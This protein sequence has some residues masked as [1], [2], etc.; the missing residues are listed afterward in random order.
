FSAFPTL[1]GGTLVDTFNVT[2]A[3]TADLK[4]GDGVDVFNIGAVLTGSVDGE[5]A[6]GT[7]SGSQ[8]AD[9]A[10]TGPSGTIGVS[11]TNGGVSGGFSN[12]NTITGSGAGTLTGSNNASTWALGATKTYTDAA[13]VATFSGF[14]TLQGGTAIDTFNV[15]AATTADLKGGGGVDVFNIGAAL[16]GSVDG[17]AGADTFTGAG[18]SISGALTDAAGTSTLNGTITAGS[19]NLTGDVVLG[20]TTSLNTSA[21]AGNI[22]FQGTLNG[23]TD[24]AEDLTLTAGTGN[25]DFD[26]VVGSTTDLGDVVIVSA[27]NVTA[28]EAFNANTLDVTATNISM[29]DVTTTGSQSYNGA[30]SFG[31]DL[32]AVD[33]T[34]NNAITANGTGNQTFDAG[35]GTLWARSTINKSTAGNLTLAGDTLI[36]LDGAVTVTGDLE[37]DDDTTVADGL[38]LTAGNDL[39]LGA[40]KT[41]TG[42]GDLTLAATAGGITEKAGDVDDN[43]QIDMAVDD[44]TLTLTQNDA[45][46]MDNFVVTNDEDTALDATS[47]GGSVT[48]TSADSWQSI[49]ARATATTGGHNIELSG[50]GNINI[51]SGGLVS[52]SGGVKVVSTGGTISILGSGTPITGTSNGTTTGVDL[53]VLSGGGK[54]A[55]V[56]I[57]EQQD[58]TIGA[59]VTLTANGTYYWQSSTYDDRASVNFKPDG[60]PIDIAIYLGSYDVTTGTTGGDATVDCGV[61]MAANSTMVVDAF[62]KVDIGSNF[63]SSWSNGQANGLELVSRI[64]GIIEEATGYLPYVYEARGNTL[65]SFMDA[66]LDTYVLRGR[67]LLAEVLASVSAVPIAVPVGFKLEERREVE[68]E[69]KDALTQWLIEELGE[70]NVQIYLA[71][72]Y[73]PTLNTDLRPYKAAAKLKDLTEILKDEGGLRVTAL[74]E[75]V[76]NSLEKGPVTVEQIRGNK[77]A[78]QWLDSLAAYVSILNTEIGLAADKSVDIAMKKYGSGLRP[79]GEQ[80]VAEWVRRYVKPAG[81]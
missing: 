61:S 67:V 41:I 58:L 5:A 48:S 15:T 70:G 14:G 33:I 49:T 55:I 78:G 29:Q 39:K 27:A 60:Q 35:T 50:S 46:D 17:E 11:G 30:A 69:D 68:E 44:K 31:G 38:T 45:L 80:R 12:I 52:N 32:S 54:A 18:G 74:V 3:T 22:S 7:L 73:Q 13:G 10:I 24:F 75:I 63:E 9:V 62:N 57:S 72:A 42:E 1:Q 77:A 47:T 4:G 23:T 21:G 25:I 36:N 66:G 51:A 43:V 19:V 28:D 40:G 2:A 79:G 20:S 71:R 34:F 64:I 37:L 16:T 6:G 81:V 53:P 56:I 8:I 76:T 59:N 65:P 26:G